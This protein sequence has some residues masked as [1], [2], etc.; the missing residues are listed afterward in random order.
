MSIDQKIDM[1]ISVF[2]TFQFSVSGLGQDYE[3]CRTQ[4]NALVFKL[5]RYKKASFCNSTIDANT[6]TF[7][8]KALLDDLEELERL[9]KRFTPSP[10]TTL[11][12]HFDAGLKD[13]SYL[14]MPAKT[15]QTT[16]Q[17]ALRLPSDEPVSNVSSC[18]IPDRQQYDLLLDRLK[19]KVENLYTTFPPNRQM[20]KK[21]CEDCVKEVGESDHQ[22]GL[23]DR[24][25][26]GVDKTLAD[27]AKTKVGYANTWRNVKVQKDDRSQFGHNF[28]PEIA[29]GIAQETAPQKNSWDHIGAEKSQSHFGHNYGYKTPYPD[30]RSTSPGADDP[31]HNEAR[32]SK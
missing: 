18:S 24:A 26:E 14:S 4:F 16:L 3:H 17:N 13:T 9:S 2:Q 10:N 29:R 31:R 30:K 21:L 6:S 11:G 25:C 15:L 19:S 20:D 8:S 5:I 7:N 32:Y 12:A 22:L 27:T 28:A 1:I 23:L